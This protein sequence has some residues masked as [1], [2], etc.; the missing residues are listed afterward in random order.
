MLFTGLALVSM[1]VGFATAQATTS[2]LGQ[3]PTFAMSIRLKESTARAGSEIIV[4]IDL[5]NKSSKEIRFYLPANGPFLYTFKVFDRNGKPAPLTPIGQ[6]IAS[7]TGVYKG[8]KGETRLIFGG[9]TFS[10]VVAPGGTLHEVVV[11][12][13][14]VDLSQPNQ[15]TIRL[16]RTDPYTK[17]V[18][19]SNATTLTVTKQE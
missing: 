13:D 8:K 14:Y 5:T 3:Q 10:A 1:Y 2:A 19:A 9:S 17:L 12:S 11:L 18:V 16:E 4:D 15:Y 6:A 7:G